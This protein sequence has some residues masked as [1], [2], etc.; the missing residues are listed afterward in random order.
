MPALLAVLATAGEIA[1]VVMSAI[2][3]IRATVML[4]GYVKQARK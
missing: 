1:T 3:V 4:W 2:A